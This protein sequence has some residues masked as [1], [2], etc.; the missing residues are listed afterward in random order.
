M[1]YPTDVRETLVKA[2]NLAVGMIRLPNAL[3][4][5]AYTEFDTTGRLGETVNVVYPTVDS[6]KA[7]NITNG[8]ISTSAISTGTIAV[9]IDQKMSSSRVVRAYDQTLSG[10][11]QLAKFSIA[12]A[13]EEVLQQVNTNLATLITAGNFNSYAAITGGADIFT[14]ANLTTA[15]ANLHGAGVPL[16]PGDVFFVTHSQVYG[17]MMSATEFINQAIVGTN[18][19][20]S[21]QQNG[22]LLP[23]L[24]ARILADPAMPLPT[25]GM[26]SG[27]FFNRF[28]LC[29][30]TALQPPMNVSGNIVETVVYPKPNLPVQIQ[31]SE[32]ITKQ[33]LII[34]AF[35]IH[36]VKVGRK[37]Y[38]SF[39]LS[40]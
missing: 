18:A 36:G 35:S 14:R 16:T 4:D 28:A 17:N 33:G 39:C 32:D 3:I 19:A 26:Y 5:C 7:T 6:S 40:T 23:Q 29:L 10:V 21:V 37:D 30:R 25:A 2:A 8:D 1:A 24:G 34:H 22:F 31:M 27:L 12:P 15:W 13:I 38:G 20:E 9:K 11:E